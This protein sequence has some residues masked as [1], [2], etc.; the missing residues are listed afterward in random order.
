MG[1]FGT[2]NCGVAPG[3]LNE[4]FPTAARA[5]GAGFAY[6]AGAAMAAV[7]PTFIG[8]L[9]DGGMSLATPMA[10][11]IAAAGLVVILLV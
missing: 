1:M 7:G 10:A 5:V 11:C 3:Y 9:Q 2:G 4:R 8:S 6:Q